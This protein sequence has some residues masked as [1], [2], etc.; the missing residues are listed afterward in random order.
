MTNAIVTTLKWIHSHTPEEIMAKMPEELVGADK[1]L[2]L[3]ALKNTLPMYSQTGKMDP[4][5]AQAVLDVFSQS[6]PDV[7][8]ANDRPV[9]DLHQQVRRGGGQGN[10]GIAMPGLIERAGACKSA[11]ADLR[12]APS[13]VPEIGD[14]LTIIRIDRRSNHLMQRPLQ[15]R[16]GRCSLGRMNILSIQSHVAYG[17]VGNAAAVFPLQRLGVEVWPIHTVQFSNHTGY[18]AWKGQVF[19]AAHD[20]R[21]DRRHRR[22]RRAAAVRRRALRLYG[23]GRYRR[24]HPRRGGDGARANPAARYCCDPVIGDVGRGVFVR[25][26]IPEFMRERAVPAA[27]VITPNQFELDYLVRPRQQD[28]GRGARRGQGAARR[29]VRA[30]SS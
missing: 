21:A 23:L 6:S 19:D 11:L 29:W 17:H 10:V 5:G 8:K 26:G 22:A 7:A 12:E 30:R 14:E 15:S 3:A 24:R 1:A 16:R 13:R 20:P 2:Y 28:D 27:D 18:G 25:P 4:K 9:E